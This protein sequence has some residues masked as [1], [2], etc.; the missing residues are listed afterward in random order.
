MEGPHELN[1]LV[2]DQKCLA[3]GYYL[4]SLDAP[5][6][7][8]GACPGQFAMLKCGDGYDPFLRRPLSIHQVDE[9]NG[10]VLF[11][12][13]VRGKGTE[14]LARREKGDRVSLLGPL[15][16]GFSSEQEGKKGLLVGAGIGIAPL[17][18]LASVL[19]KRRW[20]LVILMGARTK[21]G[22]LCSEEFERYGRVL[23]ATEDG[24][25]G[26]KGTVMDLLKQEIQNSS[27]HKI[28]ACGP[29]PVLKGVQKM[30]FDKGIPAELSL[31]ERMACGVG[32]CLGCTC[33]GAKGDYLRVCREGPV[34][35]AGEVSIDG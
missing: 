21:D 33:Q 13:Q 7:A 14:L 30:S 24:S 25:L 5:N 6:L 15:G 28:F 35:A 23:T 18:F 26:L 16:R 31:E 12:Y 3:E 29:I 4:L 34:F 27:F 19:A 17:L 1:C 9:E 32:A 10:E 8:E 22:I 20:E 2:N 11:L